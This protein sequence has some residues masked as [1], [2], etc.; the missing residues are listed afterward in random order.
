MKLIEGAMSKGRVWR[1]TG[2]EID[3]LILNGVETV[4][5]D[6]WKIRCENAGR[7]KLKYKKRI[8][9]EM[10]GENKE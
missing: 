10:T 4:D 3:L 9:P 6:K 8:I 2:E 1:K 5:E 7:T